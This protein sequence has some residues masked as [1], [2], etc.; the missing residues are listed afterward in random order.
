[1]KT[2]LLAK[3][4]AFRCKWT[5]KHGNPDGYTY[6]VTKEILVAEIK[7]RLLAT[8]GNDVASDIRVVQIALDFYVII[9]D[10]PTWFYNTVEEKHKLDFE[11]QSQKG[12]SYVKLNPNAP[13]KRYPYHTSPWQY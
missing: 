4:F 10:Q 1:M 6:A 7:R 12:D 11:N 13:G 5:D 3:T 9:K 8:R 2:K